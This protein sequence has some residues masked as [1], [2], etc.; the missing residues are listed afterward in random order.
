MVQIKGM[1][2]F[3]TKKAECHVSSVVRSSKPIIN[4]WTTS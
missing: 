1:L 2:L 3:L 4:N